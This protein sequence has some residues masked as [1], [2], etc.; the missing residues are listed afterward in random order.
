MWKKIKEQKYLTLAKYLFLGIILAVIVFQFVTNSIRNQGLDFNSLFD[1]EIIKY[2]ISTLVGGF[3]GGITFILISAKEKN[4]K[5]IEEKK[6]LH[7][8]EKNTAY[9]IEN[10]IAF[11]IAGLVYKILMNWFDITR[12]KNLIKALFS[13]DFIIDYIGIVLAMTVF[14]IILSIGMKKRLNL[15]FDK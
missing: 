12:S 9:F 5:I 7:I 10:I 2:F 3:V 15:L 14:S 13:T 4:K 6:W 11:S 8:K 1:K